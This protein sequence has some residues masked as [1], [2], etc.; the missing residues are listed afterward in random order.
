MNGFSNSRI[1]RKRIVISFAFACVKKIFI[2]FPAAFL[3]AGILIVHSCRNDGVVSPTTSENEER[4]GV[5]FVFPAHGMTP[6]SNPWYIFEWTIHKDSS[7]SRIAID[8]KIRGGNYEQ[9]YE[10]PANPANHNIKLSLQAGSIYTFRI[11]NIKCADGDTSSVFVR[12][13]TSPDMSFYILR[14]YPSSEVHQGSVDTI[15]IRN[16]SGQKVAFDLSTDNGITWKQ[17]VPFGSN[18]NW[19]VRQDTGSRCMIKMYA[20]DSAK[21]HFTAGPFRIVNHDLASFFGAAISSGTTWWL[22]GKMSIP[23]NNTLG[24]PAVFDLSTDDGK[25]WK[26][27]VALGAM[28]AFVIDD[29]PSD[30][31]R[32]RMSNADRS[33]VTISNR[34]RIGASIEEYIPLAKNKAFGYT[35]KEITYTRVNPSGVCTDSNYRI[36]R[37]IDIYTTDDTIIYAC[38]ITDY[39]P[40]RRDF[41][42]YIGEA[43]HGFRRLAATFEPFNLV[44]MKHFIEKSISGESNRLDI[45]SDEYVSWTIVKGKGI[46]TCTHSMKTDNATTKII[47]WTLGQ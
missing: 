31:C 5:R 41:T 12:E 42:A 19:A 11:R 43:M 25:S 34:F 30:N 7:I 35:K 9:L 15:R 20:S 37:I 21:Y 44:P 3:V 26:E 24:T 14:P 8:A 10:G 28:P 38:S 23:V 16:L 4:M 1:S 18:P 22:G 46:V 33:W 6:L 27:V 47:T 29:G 17:I 2:P 36:I 13:E 45:Q 40:V 32:I 39:R